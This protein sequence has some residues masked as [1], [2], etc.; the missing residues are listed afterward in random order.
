M[1]GKREANSG[2]RKITK[3]HLIAFLLIAMT[4]ITNMAVLYLCRLSI[5]VGFTG[6]L[7]YLTSMIALLQVALGYVLGHYFKKSAKENTQGG[8]VYDTAVTTR[9]DI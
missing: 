9:R 8:I 1:S 5:L 7:P 4:F 6:A 2:K 3:S